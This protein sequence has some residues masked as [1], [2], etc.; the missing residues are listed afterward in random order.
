MA[1]LSKIFAA[2]ATYPY[3]VV[4]SRLQ[5]NRPPTHLSVLIPTGTF[6]LVIHVVQNRHA[7]SKGHTETR[8]TKGPLDFFKA[9]FR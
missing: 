4:I 3:Q 8:Q 2:T 7:E 9:R 5:V 6:Q 1:S